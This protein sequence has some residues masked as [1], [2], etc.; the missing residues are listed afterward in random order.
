MKRLILI[1]L[2]IFI[3]TCATPKVENNAKFYNNR[4]I[5]WARKGQHEKAI[6]DF[7]KAIEID[8]RYAKAYYNRGFAYF[9]KGQYE[10][11]ISDF[12]KAIELNPRYADA[13]I[14]RGVAYGRKGQHDQ[15]G[16]HKKQHRVPE[17][18]RQPV[19]KGASSGHQLHL[20]DTKQVAKR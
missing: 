4:G 11:A 13:Y 19:R 18:G 16:Q 6:A 20:E 12:T 15:D 9:L 3:S 14:N 7:T 10:Q 8:P 2:A 17:V 1:A 5:D